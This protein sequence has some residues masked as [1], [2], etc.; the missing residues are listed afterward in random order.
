MTHQSEEKD[1]EYVSAGQQMTIMSPSERSA[2]KVLISHGQQM[3]EKS[4]REQEDNLNYNSRK[5]FLRGEATMEAIA[6]DSN[7]NQT[8]S[9]VNEQMDHENKYSLNQTKNSMVSEKSNERMRP[10]GHRSSLRSN[11]K[12]RVD[13]NMAAMEQ[14]LDT[15]PNKQDHEDEIDDDFADLIVNKT[16]S[17]HERRDS[18]DNQ[19]KMSELK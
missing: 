1:R 4:E 8:Q 14:E 3:T 6:T 7:V 9:I 10:G 17:I 13:N 18:N 5:N 12:P 15:S 2:G 16:N 19:M 11:S